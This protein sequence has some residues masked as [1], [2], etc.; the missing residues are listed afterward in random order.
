MAIS[1]RLVGINKQCRCI[2]DARNG[3]GLLG[4]ALAARRAADSLGELRDHC[5]ITFPGEGEAKARLVNIECNRDL[6]H[7]SHP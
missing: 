4:N 7:G 1:R 5:F 3:P 2:D 6:G